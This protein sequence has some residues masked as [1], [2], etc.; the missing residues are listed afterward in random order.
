MSNEH[1]E[2]QFIEVVICTSSG[3]YPEEGAENMPVHQ[4]LKVQLEKAGRALGIT[5]TSAFVATVDG[6]QLNF[7]SSYVELGLT[8]HVEIDWGRSE[9]GGGSYA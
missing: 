3:F 1:K 4:K 6:R 2:D 7:E 9:G 8:G 5:D